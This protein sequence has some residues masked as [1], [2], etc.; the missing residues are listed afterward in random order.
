M[1]SIPVL[2]WLGPQVGALP[3]YLAALAWFGAAILLL[4][5]F[6]V[7]LPRGDSIGVSG[8]LSAAAIV[9][10]SPVWAGVAVLTSALATSVLRM[11]R[12][13]VRRLVTVVLSRGTA[14][15]AASGSWFLSHSYAPDF[16]GY[17]LVPAAFLLTEFVVAQT[18]SAVWTKRPLPRQLLGNMG[19]QAPLIAAQWSVSVLLLVTYGSMLEWSLIPAVALLLLMR[20]SYALYLNIR[21]TYRTTVE[22]LVQAAEGQD[23]RRLGHAERTAVIARAIAMK[24]GLSAQ[25]VERISFAALLHDLGELAE[26]SSVEAEDP[27][28]RASA[29]SVVRGV[30]YFAKVGPVLEVCDGVSESPP[31]ADDL[32]AAFIVALASDIDAEYYPE[33]AEAHCGSALETVSPLTAAAVKAKVV[34]TA[35]G[36]GYRVPAVG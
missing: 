27:V 12:F 30:E 29:A 31:E 9:I 36:L 25:E 24:A 14:I 19:A 20:Q 26:Q 4:D 16:V 21:E 33:V 11:R 35:L 6:D 8:A 15:A 23:E 2:D 32:R 7:A 22:V 10:F 17:V 13:R 28:T 18:V 3:V 5:L 34:G 1:G